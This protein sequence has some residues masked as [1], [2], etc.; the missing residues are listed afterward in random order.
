MIAR[1]L[2]LFI[3]LG[4]TGT[5]QQVDVTHQVI[6]VRPDCKNEALIGTTSLEITLLEA[7]RVVQLDGSK[8]NIENV[9]MKEE[10]SFNY[11]PDLIKNNLEIQLGKKYEK[12]AQLTIEIS[13]RTNW[14]NE[15]DP[16]NIWGSLG[17]GVRFFEPSTTEP[18]RQKQIW[19]VGEPNG[20]A[21]WFPGNHEPT[22]QRTTEMYF[23]IERPLQV[24]ANGELAEVTSNED[25]TRTFHWKTLEEH[26]PH[27][28]SFVAGRYL[29]VTQQYEDV[30]IVSYCY[31]HEADATAATAERLPDM[32][33]FYSEITDV[34]YPYP[35]YSQVFVQEFAGWQ[36][37]M[38]TSTI[39]ENMVDDWVTHKDFQWLW[40][41]VESEAL[42][43]Q[44]F[45]VSLTPEQWGDAWLTK[46][47][48]RH[49]SGLYNEYK[50]GSNEFLSYQHN[51]QLTTYFIDWN[52][53]N[54]QPV[55]QKQITDATAFTRSNHPYMKGASVLHMLRKE[56]GEKVWLQVLKTFTK[57][58][59]GKNV[60][61]ADF[62]RVVQEVSGRDMAWFFSQWVRG[63]G[64]PVFEIEKQ[65]DAD[66]QE[67]TLNV[68]QVQ[69]W[70]TLKTNYP[71][72]SFFAGNLP[73]E[74][75]DRVETIEIKA[76]KENS[77]KFKLIAQPNF[78]NFDY[79]STWI[80]Q[81]Q[82]EKTTDEWI[83]QFRDSKDILARISA[84]GQL[85]S[86]AQGALPEEERE[87]IHAAMRS[88]ILASDT[89]WRLKMLVLWQLQGLLVQ[90]GTLTL[91]APTEQMLLEVIE[92]E[93]SWVKSSAVWFLGMTADPNYA[94]LYI[95][96]FDDWSDRVTNAAAIAL[97]KTKSSLAF[98]ALLE[99][100]HKPSWKNQSLISSLN[101]LQWL[102]DERGE[103]L[104]LDAI[105][106][107]TATHWT[108]STPI[109]DHRLSAGNTLNALG[110]QAKGYEFIYEQ[111]QAA[112][113]EEDLNDVLYN[114][115]QI[116]N[117]ADPRGEEAFKRL[118]ET[119][120]GN[121]EV[122]AA[123]EGYEQQFLSRLD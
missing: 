9:R 17:T 122:I 116:A 38:M 20:N 59:V 29:P 60:S 44:W 36:G 18:K 14:V 24:V 57:N 41:I 62:Q 25:G 74:I 106:N 48:A 2:I 87:R 61:T 78:I 6:S 96:L 22:D 77:Y 34:P 55:A 50:N 1:H 45:G 64:H 39:T 89:Y 67:L 98:P 100:Q 26:A 58:Y 35:S 65:W 81:T 4:L 108:L 109:W 71:T 11:K 52:G 111:L 27:L 84:L 47:F 21:L 118:K 73:I 31:P 54:I 91:D 99:L 37:N 75:D 33:R 3:L 114:A 53:G 80:Q 113:D 92:K 76:Q 30:S 117:L 102:G 107:N 10:L 49:L 7:A 13:Y 42:A 85:G 63:I 56:L 32:M 103:V 121:A 95:D 110:A 15:T 90:N 40:D 69:Q 28:T 101:G 86:L 51:P 68:K 23:T 66:K 123:I 115:L 88:V 119:Y 16:A 93:E 79:E 120:E 82:F 5:A 72:T 8:L 94:T 105:K 70:D 83:N 112:I 12:G 97:G 43:S 46:A 19:S 104:A